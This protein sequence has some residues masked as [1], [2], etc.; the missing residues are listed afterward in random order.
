MKKKA[1]ALIASTVLAVQMVPMAA[2]AQSNQQS[3]ITVSLD[4]ANLSDVVVKSGRTFVPL[5]D[6]A[7]RVSLNDET[8]TVKANK[9]EVEVTLAG[10]KV[11]FTIG[12][13]TANVDNTK[14]VLDAA[15]FLAANKAYVPVTSLK[16]IFGKQVAWNQARKTVSVTTTNADKAIAVLEGLENGS[17]EA[18]LQF[19]DEGY[20]QHNLT[21]PTGRDV[22]VQALPSLKAAGTTVS[23]RR[24]LVDGDF[25]AVHSEYNF[26]GPKAGFDIFRFENGKIVE[27]WDNLQTLAANNPS[28]HSMLDGETKIV[29]LDKTEENKA[30]VKSF[31]ENILMGKNPN[32]LTSYFDG[33]N[34]IQHNP[35]IADGL[36]GLGAALQAMAKQGIEMKYDQI[37]QV[38]GQGNFVLVASEGTFAG[39]HTAY[40]DLFRV[41]NGKIAEHWDVLETIPAAEQHANQ[42]GKF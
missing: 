2:S 13:K 20:I 17:A 22:I 11:V 38:I 34:Y 31:V 9:N 32:L 10:K 6:L 15:P 40:Y 7:K 30:Y 39:N 12:S 26:G 4:G 18:M 5:K 37:H 33:D 1:A 35:S 16:S 19:V 14:I 29:D 23:A 41:E 3:K 25:V 28:G 21:L 24:I 36:S 42:N 27:H 8:L